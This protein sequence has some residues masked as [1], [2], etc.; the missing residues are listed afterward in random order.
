MLLVLLLII[1]LISSS[2]IRFSF[3]QIAQPFSEKAHSLCMSLIPERLTVTDSL[4]ALVCGQNLDSFEKSNLY[5]QTGLIHLFVVSGSHLILMNVV[6]KKVFPTIEQKSKSALYFLAIRWLLLVLYAC[7]CE[8]N[9]PVTRSL[10]S[11]LLAD[12]LLLKTKY[13]PRSYCLLLAGLGSLIFHPTWILSLSLQ[14]SWLAAIA[15]EINQHIFK[16]TKTVATQLT[17]YSLFFLVFSLLGF[18]Q[19]SVIVCAYFFTP[20]LE[21]ILFP[22][23]F[24]CLPFPFL[25][26]LFSF[27]EN[28]LITALKS[29]EFYTTPSESQWPHYQILNWILI[30]VLHLVLHFQTKKS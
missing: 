3:F 1:L 24:L 4:S 14:M 26:S 27:L 15:I 18:P 2:S 11:L 6:L 28:T 13:W 23:A 10:F 30:V 29:F 25:T 21:W 22:L 20:V 17:F 19:I 12:S 8:L 5:I 7:A 16:D 9:P